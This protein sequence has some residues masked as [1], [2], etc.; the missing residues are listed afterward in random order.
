MSD[1][2]ILSGAGALPVTLAN[3]YPEAVRVVFHGVDHAMQAPLAQHRFEKLSV[4]FEDLK[5]RGVTRVVLAGAMSRPAL[6]PTQLDPFMMRLAPRLMA[7]MQGGDDAILRLIIT[8]FEEQG[9]AVVGAHDL[10]PEITVLDGVIAGPDPSDAQL[11]DAGRATDIL[12]A[13]SPLDVGQGAVVSAGLCLGIETLQGTDALLRFVADTPEHLRRAKGGVLV[14]APKRG[15]DLRV[16][17]PAIG[18]ETVRNAAAA[19]LD[20]IVV[21]SGKVVLLDRADTLKALNETGLFL[22]GQVL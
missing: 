8:V 13:L 4:L 16:D 17:M 10:L 3:A 20:G 1:L 11:A 12:L 21:S 15:Q 19:G 2:A 5:Q 18:P 6:D 14:K 7:A 9:F 22:L